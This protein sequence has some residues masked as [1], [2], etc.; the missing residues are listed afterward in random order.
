M[1]SEIIS[2]ETVHQNWGKMAAIE[3]VLNNKNVS[4]NTL[5]TIGGV[6]IKI[7]NY[8]GIQSFI[9]TCSHSFIYVVDT[10]M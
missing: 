1:Q 9:H 4:F 7:L 5:Y 10:V 2:Q 3:K 6:M 8:S